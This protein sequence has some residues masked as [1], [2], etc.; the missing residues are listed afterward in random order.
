MAKEEAVREGTSY[1][2][3]NRSRVEGVDGDVVQLNRTQYR[4]QLTMLQGMCEEDRVLVGES[5]YIIARAMEAWTMEAW[6]STVVGL[7]WSA[8]LD[9]SFY[10]ITIASVRFSAQLP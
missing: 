5:R 2:Q 1:G 7:R 3:S 9:T 10:R 4:G 8:V 6:K